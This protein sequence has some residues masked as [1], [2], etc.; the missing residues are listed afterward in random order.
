[1]LDSHQAELKDMTP[2][3]AMRSFFVKEASR[4]L[5]LDLSGDANTAMDSALDQ[6][7]G[8][9]DEGDEGENEGDDEPVQED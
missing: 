6:P 8:A 1:V 5:T 4:P 9:E 2:A 3:E 7:M